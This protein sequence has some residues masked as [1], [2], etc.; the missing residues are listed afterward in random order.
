[1]KSVLI[2]GQKFF[3]FLLINKVFGYNCIREGNKREGYDASRREKIYNRTRYENLK[4]KPW[5]NRV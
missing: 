2:R 3:K 5:A 4:N 1:M